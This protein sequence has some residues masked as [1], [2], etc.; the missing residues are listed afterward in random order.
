MQLVETVRRVWWR[1][2]GGAEKPEPPA[3]PERLH[4]EAKTVEAD[5]P[6]TEEPAPETEEQTAPLEPE[7]EDADDLTAIRGIGAAT[8]KRL[9]AAGIRT[10]AQLAGANPDDVSG[11]L[12]NQAQRSNVEKWI[13]QARELAA[14]E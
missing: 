10:Y 14:K 1:I 13:G 11:A 3:E 2:V 12:N 5:R 9:H 7:G 4:P 6:S 8:Q